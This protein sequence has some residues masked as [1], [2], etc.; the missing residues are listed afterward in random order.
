MI[1][2]SHMV[3]SVSIFDVYTGPPV[4]KGKK[5]LAFSISFQSGAKTLTDEE[6]AEERR[7]IVQR[8]RRELGAELRS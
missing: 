5:S 7:R 3:R 2:D 1:E 4:P 6:V 8:L